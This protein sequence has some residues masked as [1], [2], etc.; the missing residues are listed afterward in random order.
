LWS[1]IAQSFLVPLSGSLLRERHLGSTSPL[2]RLR[3]PSGPSH[4]TVEKRGNPPRRA[5]GGEKRDLL[6]AEEA[7]R[8]AEQAP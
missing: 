7:A 8:I 6:A 3:A 2:R 1:V 4:P 5:E